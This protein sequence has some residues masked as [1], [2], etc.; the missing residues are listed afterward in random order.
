MQPLG[1]PCEVIKGIYT[2]Y[3][4]IVLLEAG[5]NPRNAARC[6]GFVTLYA[7]R[8][9]LHHFLDARFNLTATTHNATDQLSMLAAF[10]RDE[11]RKAAVAARPAA[12]PR[13]PA[14]PSSPARGGGSYSAAAQSAP[15]PPTQ[16]KM[17]YGPRAPTD[18][19]GVVTYST[20]G[21][22]ITTIAG[23]NA[24]F[25][26]PF[27]PGVAESAKERADRLDMW[28]FLVA[29]SFH[30]PHLSGGLRV[31]DIVGFVEAIRDFGVT[32]GFEDTLDAVT[33]M[34]S[35][36]KRGKTWPEYATE[37]AKIRTVLNQE[38]DP[39]WKIGD[40]LLPGFILRGMQAESKFDIELTLLR[41]THPPPDV[42][43]IMSTLGAKAREH[44]KGQHTLTALAAS[45]ST[46][47]A[48]VAT[49]VA[50]PPA[51]SSLQ[52]CRNF[53][54]DGR[55]R[56]DHP[57]SG[58]WCIHSH[59]PTEDLKRIA[60]QKA[61]KAGGKPVARGRTPKPAKVTQQQTSDGC[62]RCG[63]KNHGIDDCTE[64]VKGN[65]A[66]PAANSSSSSLNVTDMAAAIALAMQQQQA[67]AGD[68]MGMVADPLG[69]GPSNVF[70]TSLM[71]H[72][73]GKLFGSKKNL[74]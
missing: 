9:A 72:E 68:A 26:S 20:E 41:K 63:S 40:Q 45:T 39:R 37:V 38:S 18:T 46:P 34:A 55:C 59:G 52:L 19:R 16:V 42:D 17:E 2:T 48:S 15:T 74:T 23:S 5:P 21:A 51:G 58:K 54:R 65:V 49:P 69:V 4:G 47:A 1:D 44:S 32:M 35:L 53:E 57:A 70:N 6:L 64:E 50:R 8:N 3:P 36:T 25:A 30:H 14:S 62:Y 28:S 11:E 56:Y 27:T 29:V 73:L 43:H 71:D 24:Y 22:R 67:S 60:A 12:S 31:G 61:F 13:P 66:V 33:A 10:D 7:S